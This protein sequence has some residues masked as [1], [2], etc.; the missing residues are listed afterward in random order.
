MKQNK[1]RC[2]ISKLRG[3][4]LLKKVRTNFGLFRSPC[5]IT[6]MRGLFG[7]ILLEKMKQK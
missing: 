4:L 6:Y 5:H 1:A 3:N 7:K 2:H